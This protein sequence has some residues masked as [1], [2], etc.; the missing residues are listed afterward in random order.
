MREECRI[1]ITFARKPF[2][3]E[4][5]LLSE[6]LALNANDRTEEHCVQDWLH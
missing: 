4:Y 6:V 1:A 5:N 3:L 2:F